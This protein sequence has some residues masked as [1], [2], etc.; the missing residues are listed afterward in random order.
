MA[1]SISLILDGYDI[2]PRLS[3][4]APN[5]IELLLERRLLIEGPRMTNLPL[6]L[7]LPR[8]QGIMQNQSLLSRWR[9]TWFFDNW[10]NGQRLA[11]MPTR[12]LA[13]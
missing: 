5:L 12:A 4:L 1:L 11:N 2:G 10:L 7:K 3:D 13:L 8:T 6:D 9:R